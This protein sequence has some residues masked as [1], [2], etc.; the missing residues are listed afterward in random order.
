MRL[1]R[2]GASA[3]EFALGVSVLLLLAGGIAEWGWTMRCQ[4]SAISAAREGA[5]TGSGTAQLDDPELAAVIRSAASLDSAGLDSET[6]TI[7]A[8]QSGVTPDV[9]LT[10]E[11]SLPH[12][13]LVP[14]V[15]SLATLSHSFTMRMQEQ[16]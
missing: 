13:S 2:G 9:V 10:V 4:T 14:L 3:I 1:G 15:P 5:R 12:P 16:P 8:T 6:A 11:L 7:T